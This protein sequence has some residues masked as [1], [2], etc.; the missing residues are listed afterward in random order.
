[1]QHSV[2]VWRTRYRQSMPVFEHVAG[3]LNDQRAAKRRLVQLPAIVRVRP[4]GANALV[5]TGVALLENVSSHGA[6][7][8]MEKPLE[9]GTPLRFD[10]PG[11]A[12]SG[13]GRVVFSRAFESPM[14]VRFAV[15]V[16]LDRSPVPAT[17]IDRVL[18]WRWRS[19]T[20]A[21]RGS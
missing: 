5:D 17:A 9:D 10:V 11:T 7:L 20:H 2:P 13:R 12:L 1:M 4:K 8:I 15:G 14:N 3:W 18:R 21:L 19:T 16:A 6:Q